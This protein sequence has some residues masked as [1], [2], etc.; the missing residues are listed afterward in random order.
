MR[1]QKSPARKKLSRAIKTQSTARPWSSP[2]QHNSIRPPAEPSRVYPLS[3][4]STPAKPGKAAASRS[5]SVQPRTA[6]AATQV[7]SQRHSSKTSSSLQRCSEASLPSKASQRSSRSTRGSNKIKAAKRHGVAAQVYQQRLECQAQQKQPEAPPP[8]LH[9][10][11]VQLQHTTATNG[12]IQQHTAIHEQPLPPHLPQ[13]AAP[14]AACMPCSGPYNFK[15]PGV[16]QITAVACEMMTLVSMRAAMSQ[17][18]EGLVH[19]WQTGFTQPFVMPMQPAMPSPT[20]AAAAPFP[21]PAPVWTDTT[22]VPPCSP[23]PSQPAPQPSCRPVQQPWASPQGA[24]PAARST[25]DVLPLASPA[26]EA[27]EPQRSGRSTAPCAPAAWRGDGGAEVVAVEVAPR[28]GSAAAS[29]PAGGPERSRCMSA[30]PRLEPGGATVGVQAHPVTPGHAMPVDPGAALITSYSPACGQTAESSGRPG[31]AA[32]D[33]LAQPPSAPR[34]QS[35]TDRERRGG[36]V[37]HPVGALGAGAPLM[38]AASGSPASGG[39]RGAPG[40]VTGWD[41]KSPLAGSGGFAASKLSGV[42]WS[43]GQSLAS[44]IVNSESHPSLQDVVPGQNLELD[45]RTVQV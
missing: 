27:H 19:Q 2:Q 44:G 36:D 13:G 35:Q 24:V 32:G 9:V 4:P 11:H 30:V 28:P 22:A 15:P 1:R 21:A 5:C 7:P 40:E 12:G 14:A 10:E 37:G 29:A 43:D 16:E 31:G 17:V 18:M 39:D 41:C 20:P 23:Q 25:V 8:Q 3:A 42:K 45:G 34:R 26:V 38:A 33:C 6:T